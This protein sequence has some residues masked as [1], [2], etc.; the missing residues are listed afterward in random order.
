VRLLFVSGV[1]APASGGS[2]ISAQTLLS[3]LVCRDHHVLVL[4]GR[5]TG[6]HWEQQ[7]EREDL[8]DIRRCREQELEQVF[9]S[10]VTAFRPDVVLTQLLWSE[11]VMLWARAE[12]LPTVLFVRSA[13]GE[14]DLS[15]GGPY[16]PTVVIANSGVTRDF[17]RRRWDRECV[18]VP[19]LIRLAECAAVMRV[20]PPFITM[21]NPTRE[22]GGHIFRAV[23]EDMADR[24]F[25][26]VEGWHNWKNACGEW[27]VELLE[28][29]ARGY[30]STLVRLPKTID[31]DGVDNV[32]VIDATPDVAAV[33]ASTRI[34]MV[35][36]V[37]AEPY[38]RVIVEAMSNAIPVL[39]SGAG[40]TDEAA[41]GA[42]VIVH[43]ADDAGAWIAAIR[44]L[45]DQDRYDALAHSSLTRAH[46]YDLTAEVNKAV[47]AIR[48][49]GGSD[50]SSA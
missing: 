4:T 50:L 48:C 46:R 25:L 18:V 44:Q 42:G 34:L 40:S 13:G 7:E 39:Y 32:T 31:F 38:G 36:S 28:S 14:I 23:A 15:A 11:R 26:V 5:R 47:A 37:W 6:A 16:S 27:D 45:D 17:V 3:E 2:E 12:S 49:A 24:R 20:D 9:R 22:K 21:F 43:P 30:G 41:D 29:A 33:Y 8:V 10:V 35:P 1:Y 19:P